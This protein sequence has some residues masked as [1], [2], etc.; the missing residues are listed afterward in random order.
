M[1]LSKNVFDKGFSHWFIQR[2]SALALLLFIVLLAIFNSLFLGFV[3]FLIL[4]VHFEMGLHTIIDDYT[5][6]FLSKVVTNTSV[7]LL[8]ICLVKSCFIIFFCF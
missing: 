1:I 7:D 2:I 6:D 5:H 4:L 3:L 8:M